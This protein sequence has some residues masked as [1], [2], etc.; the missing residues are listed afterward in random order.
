MQESVCL[1]IYLFVAAAGLIP[2]E[3]GDLAQLEFLRLDDNNLQ[4]TFVFVP[5]GVSKTTCSLN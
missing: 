4:G 2:T 5:T 3:L 1:D